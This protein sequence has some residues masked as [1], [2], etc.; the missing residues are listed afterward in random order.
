MQAAIPV[1]AELFVEAWGPYYG[2]AGPGD[3][4]HD[5][6]SCCNRD[7]MPLALVA[8]DTTQNILGTAAL[9][10][11][12]LETHRH[13]NPWLAAM[14]VAPDQRGKG[15]ASALITAIEDEARRL[16]FASLYSDT[17]SGSA[18]LERQGWQKLEADI[19]TLREPATLYCLDLK[20]ARR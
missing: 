1:L 8:L 16:G 7:E 6:R 2:P 13:L 3:A 10:P 15:I 14:L 17:A 5:L 9:K 19:Q 11:H 18:L 12:S 20:A 4:E